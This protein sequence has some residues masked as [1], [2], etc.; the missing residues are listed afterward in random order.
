MSFENNVHTKVLEEVN[1]AMADEIMSSVP[2]EHRDHVLN[3][4]FSLMVRNLAKPGEQ[5]LA[6]L[7]A[8][9][10]NTIIS[11]L[12]FI[13]GSCEELDKIK[14]V[15]IYNKDLPEVLLRSDGPFTVEEISPDQAHLIHMIA[16]AVGESGELADALG[17]HLLGE[18]LDV[19][20]IR[21]EVGDIL[22]YLQGLIGAL[23]MSLDEVILANKAKLLGKRYASGYSDAAAQARA[24]KPAGE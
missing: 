20:N 22:F 19:E 5:I 23:G 12:G 13:A 15:C 18:A 14:K 11:A 16:G 7:T 10:L 17:K 9:R 2:A 21:E 8:A 4:P 6:T 3:T 24:D 1:R